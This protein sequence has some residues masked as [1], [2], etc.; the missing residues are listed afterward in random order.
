MVFIST[1]FVKL[2]LKETPHT[3]DSYGLVWFAWFGWFG[4]VWFDLVW[5]GLIGLVGLHGRLVRLGFVL[6][7]LV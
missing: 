7:C 6:F 4:L 3:V 1:N 2:G 5:Y